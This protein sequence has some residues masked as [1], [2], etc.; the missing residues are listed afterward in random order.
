MVGKKCRVQQDKTDYPYGGCGIAVPVLYVSV[1]HD[2]AEL[3]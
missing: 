1:F 3:L 2:R